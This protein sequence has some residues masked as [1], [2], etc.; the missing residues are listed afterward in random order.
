MLTGHGLSTTASHSEAFSRSPNAHARTPVCLQEQGRGL[1]TQN[2]NLPPM[3]P[4]GRRRCPR[5][6]PPHTQQSSP[7]VLQSQAAGLEDSGRGRG[8]RR[9]PCSQAPAGGG[10]LSPSPGRPPCGGLMRSEVSGRAVTAAPS[11][12]SRW[13]HL[14]ACCYLC[15]SPSRLRSL[16]PPTAEGGAR[17]PPLLC[18][19]PA[20][21][22]ALHPV[23]AGLARG[24]THVL[25]GGCALRMPRGDSRPRGGEQ[26]VSPAPGS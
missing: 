26:T 5:R 9:A 18:P 16:W 25:T 6:S 13:G 10:Q 20:G 7:R 4:A 2:L 3:P 22:A 12:D 14:P 15:R 21:P 8:G 23:T 1:Y 17:P 11:V 24:R 19:A